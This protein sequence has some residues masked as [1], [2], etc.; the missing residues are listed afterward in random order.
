MNISSLVEALDKQILE[1]NIIGAFADFAADDCVTYS[2]P[3][4]KT[5]SKAQKLEALNWF[6]S[7]V[8]KT[9]KIERQGVQ[10]AGNE[11]RSQFTFEFVG[12]AGEPIAYAEVIRRTW[13]N[14][15]LVEEQYLIGQTLDAKSESAQTAPAK[16]VASKAKATPKEDGKPA[17]EPAKEAEVAA[18]TKTKVSKAKAE[19]KDDL[20]KIEGIGPKIAELLI[21]DGIDSFAKLA[22][23]KPAEI[24]TILDA[25]GKRYQMHDPA[26]WPQQA[27]LARDGKAAEL[28]KLQ[29][30]LKG[31][32][33]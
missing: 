10:V 17:T 32:R 9:V 29:D 16:V 15:K 24:K 8:A 31:G 23:A 11:S 28:K 5:I 25:A 27:A 20:T 26:T 12:K 7:G 4:H 13:K 1:G 3:N 2:Q 14:G 22:N 30:E 6:F 18:V 33:K 21:K 19:A